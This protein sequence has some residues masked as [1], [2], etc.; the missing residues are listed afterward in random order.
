MPDR[1][2]GPSSPAFDRR[3][4]VLPPGQRLAYSAD[5]WRD[6]LVSIDRG[7]ILLEC[8]THAVRRFRRGDLLCLDGMGLTA[9]YNPGPEVAVL[10]A[11]S[12]RLP[13]KR[14][15]PRRLA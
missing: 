12:R 4:V 1:S 8:D 15:E 14:T 10:T 6:A 3:V 13:P 11:T 9:I 2:H 5:E 7:A